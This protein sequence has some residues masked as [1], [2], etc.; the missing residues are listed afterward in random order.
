M[1]PNTTPSAP[2]ISAAG[3]AACVVGEAER[4]AFRR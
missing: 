2:T 4:I 3:P 1:S